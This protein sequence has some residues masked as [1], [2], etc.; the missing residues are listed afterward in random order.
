[1]DGTN[2]YTQAE[3][4][5]LDTCKLTLTKHLNFFSPSSSLT[6]YLFR[7]DLFNLF[8]FTFYGTIIV[9][10]KYLNIELILDFIVFMRLKVKGSKLNKEKKKA[11][12]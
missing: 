3:S 6:L 12:L 4:V 1:L 8:L 2:I 11:A 9:L 10:T 5:S 7:I